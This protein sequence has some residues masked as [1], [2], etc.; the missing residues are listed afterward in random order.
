MSDDEIRSL[1]WLSRRKQF[2]GHFEKVKLTANQMNELRRPTQIKPSLPN[3]RTCL[4]VT[5]RAP[6]GKSTRD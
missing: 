3:L 6:S 5:K 4:F 2:F 1:D